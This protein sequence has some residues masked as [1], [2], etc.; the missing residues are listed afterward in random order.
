MRSLCGSALSDHDSSRSISAYSASCVPVTRSTLVARA[1]G[2]SRQRWPSVP[3]RR[4]LRDGAEPLRPS[5]ELA[6]LHAHLG[7]SVPPH[8]LWEIAHLQGIALP[9][10]DYWEFVDL[11]SISDPRGVDGLDG[12]D[13]IYHLTELIQSSPL[14]VER[15]VYGMVGGGYRSQRITTSEVRFNPMK[16]NRGGER[17]LDHTI[18]AAIHGRHGELA[19]PQ[20]HAG[21][22]LMMD[23]TFSARQNAIIVEKAIRYAPR[24]VV[25]VDIAG[26]RPAPAA[27]RTATSRSTCRPRATR[28]SA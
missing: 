27:S 7:G 16:R 3:E 1:D 26:P 19:Y 4:R 15:S 18:L 22:I 11:T 5:D 28:G 2:W 24:G 20:V 23:R 8:V 25:G 10:K 6:E 13:Q 21:L 12:L 17:D 14:A 9:T